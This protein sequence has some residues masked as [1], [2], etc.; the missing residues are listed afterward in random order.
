M[1]IFHKETEE[2]K[3][4]VDLGS[5]IAATEE[6]LKQ[7]KQLFTNIGVE[8]SSQDVSKLTRRFFGPDITKNHSYIL[9]LS[10]F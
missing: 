8:C 6:Q 4:L 7:I 3:V 5:P 1:I 9:Y 10:P 2:G